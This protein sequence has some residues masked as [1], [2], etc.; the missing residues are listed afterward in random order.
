MVAADVAD[1]DADADVDAVFAVVA[2][3]S[4][5]RGWLRVA[6]PDIARIEYVLYE[7]LLA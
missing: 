4:N 2:V 7:Q 3:A 6:C 1:V 5:L